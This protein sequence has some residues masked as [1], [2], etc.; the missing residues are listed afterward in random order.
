MPLQDKIETI[1]R[2]ELGKARKM[3]RWSSVAR[4]TETLKC[5]QLLN[6]KS[7][8][9]LVKSMKDDIMKRSIYTQYLTS[10]RREL[11]LS[12]SFLNGYVIFHYIYLWF[13]FDFQKTVKE[14]LVYTYIYD[15]NKCRKVTSSVCFWTKIIW[16]SNYSKMTSQKSVIIYY[17]WKY[18]FIFHHNKCFQICQLVL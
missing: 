18:Q 7:C 3:R 14:I 5:V 17:L 12:E 4:I 16:C 11:L 13:R 8:S 15:L 10:S 2:I 6:E 1:L 9:K